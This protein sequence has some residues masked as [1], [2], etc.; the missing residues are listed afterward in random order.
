MK[1]ILTCAVTHGPAS[2]SGAPRS[3][4]PRK[5]KAQTA[6]GRPCEYQA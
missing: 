2:G 4:S 3:P 6:T 1:A 5:P